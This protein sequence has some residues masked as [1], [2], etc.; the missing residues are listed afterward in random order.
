M[1]TKLNKSGGDVMTV[2]KYKR[3]VY[4]LVCEV[5]G[6]EFQV[7]QVKTHVCRRCQKSINSKKY[8][9]KNKE[10]LKARA[11]EYREDNKEKLKEYFKGYYI[12]NKEVINEKHKT[13]YEENKD[14]L[15]AHYEKKRRERGEKPNGLSGIE[16]VAY[17]FL[18]EWFPNRRILKH[19]RKTI[20]S[21]L[22]GAY[23]E[24]DFYLPKLKLAIELNGVTHYEPIY[25][26]EKF[27]RQQVNDELKRQICRD[28]GITLIEIPLESG[29]HYD[30]YDI[31]HERLK[32]V[33][34][35]YLKDNIQFRP[36]KS[37]EMCT[38]EAHIREE[39][40]V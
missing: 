29:V 11:K 19:D 25:G 6:E 38:F 2:G 39:N 21:P 40:N 9:E 13:Y 3:K 5:C 1:R 20:K 22:T 28:K 23:L 31:Q 17:R 36:D 37:S 12:K 15:L 18:K 26:Q 30:R 27:E 35:Q 10:K 8:Y 4:T 33:M 34:Y 24:L 16:E 7:K 14:R 32:E